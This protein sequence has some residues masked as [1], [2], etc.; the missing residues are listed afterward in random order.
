MPDELDLA[1]ERKEIGLLAMQEFDSWIARNLARN[2]FKNF[3]RQCLDGEE[4]PDV[5]FFIKEYCEPGEYIE[6]K[7][8]REESIATGKKLT[9]ARAKTRR[10]IRKYKKLANTEIK[11]N[12]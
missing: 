6:F 5:E 11:D 7:R 3:L 4:C 1:S 12:Q 8:L 9:S 2:E 10:K